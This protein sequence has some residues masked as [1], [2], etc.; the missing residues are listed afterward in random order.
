MQ[1]FSINLQQNE[2]QWR[3][4][5]NKAIKYAWSPNLGGGEMESDTILKYLKMWGQ[6][7]F[8]NK[9]LQEKENGNYKDILRII[10]INI[11]FI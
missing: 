6:M 7:R 8:Q 4:S 1:M 5:I 9:R 3:I 11:I 2:Y 10:V